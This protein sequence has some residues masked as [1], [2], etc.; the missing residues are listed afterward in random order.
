MSSPALLDSSST[1]N[2]SVGALIEST[3]PKRRGRKDQKLAPVSSSSFPFLL[4]R[5]GAKDRGG[6][7]ERYSERSVVLDYGDF[8]GYSFLAARAAVDS[9]T[10]RVPHRKV[11]ELIGTQM[12]RR[13]TVCEMLASFLDDQEAMAER[14]R[15]GRRLIA[16]GTCWLNFFE[17]AA[18]LHVVEGELVL[19]RVEIG[20]ATE[21]MPDDHFVMRFR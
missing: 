4:L 14:L 7:L 12:P 15:A 10:D 18:C 9:V 11:L 16:L 13:A 2:D 6:F 5:T 8:R 21:W 17:G 3:L 1:I 19:G 20:P